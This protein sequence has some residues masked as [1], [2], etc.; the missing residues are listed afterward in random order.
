MILPSA[1]RSLGRLRVK[2][3]LFVILMFPCWVDMV[4]LV[5]YRSCN[6]RCTSCLRCWKGK[7]V[8]IKRRWQ[9]GGAVC[10]DLTP[11]RVFLKYAS[12]MM[13]ESFQVGG[14]FGK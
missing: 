12:L 4:S 7:R 11:S 13:G 8:S 2:A 9:S 6:E 14:I 5:S 10:T 1:L 3:F